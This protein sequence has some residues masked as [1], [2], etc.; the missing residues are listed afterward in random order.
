MAVNAF[1]KSSGG[2]SAWVVGGHV[3]YEWPT[4]VLNYFNSKWSFSPATEL[5]GYYL[6]GVTLSGHDINNNTDRLDEHDF[7]VSYPMQ[8]SVFLINAILNINNAEFSKFHPYVGVGIGSAIVSISGANSTQTSPFEAGINHY[9]SD[10]S[11]TV[12]AFA[13]QPKIGVQWNLNQNTSVFAEYRFLYLAATGH[14]FGST[15]YPTHVATSNWDVKIGAQK[16]NIGTVGVR[17]GL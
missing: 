6:G 8:T 14:T 13:A 15:V 3:G 2:N 17:F 1:G 7:L 10:S 12:T 5:E 11:D 9:N 4:R 16:Y